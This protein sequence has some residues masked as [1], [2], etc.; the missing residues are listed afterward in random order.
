[1]SKLAALATAKGSGAGAAGLV[2][3]ATG[4]ALVVGGGSATSGQ[5]ATAEPVA[6]GKGQGPGG[7]NNGNG[8][9]NGADGAAPAGK[10]LSL[11]YEVVGHV[12]PGSPAVLRLTV[13]NPNNQAVDLTAVTAQV[14]GVT[15]AA[16][17]GPACAVADFSLSQWSGTPRRI[18]KNSSTVVDLTVS[19]V[20]NGS[21][22]DRCKSATYTFSF[23]AKANQ[24]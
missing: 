12:A 19:M 11:R 16:G 8:V 10:S 3:V 9:G 14:D 18:A 13:A 1:M 6:L 22:Q 2:S 4:L 21:N 20:E 5:I 15:S 7:G 23:A 17:F 24:A